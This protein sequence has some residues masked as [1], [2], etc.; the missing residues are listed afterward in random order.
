MTAENK[1]KYLKDVIKSFGSDISEETRKAVI[2]QMIINA[3]T[4]PA[5]RRDGLL[6]D[7]IENFI[8]ELPNDMAHRIVEDMMKSTEKFDPTLKEHMIKNMVS[9]LQVLP[10]EVRE[11]ALDAIIKNLDGLSSESKQTLLNDILLKMDEPGV[12]TDCE[13][14]A[15]R[16]MLKA[17]IF[18]EMI[19]NSKNLNA[20]EQ[21]QIVL[22]ILGKI[23]MPTNSDVSDMVL[24]E[25]VKDIG[26][27]STEIRTR[28]LD[29]IQKSVAK[30]DTA[31]VLI[32][33]CL[34]YADC[35]P[36]DIIESLIKVDDNQDPLVVNEI[37]KNFNKLPDTYKDEYFND[38]VSKMGTFD[39]AVKHSILKSLMTNEN[40][41]LSDDTVREKCIDDLV[42][43]LAVEDIIHEAISMSP[44]EKNKFFQNLLKRSNNMDDR[45]RGMLVDE[46]LKNA[47]DLDADLRE[48][49]LES[50]F[51]NVAND[52]PVEI[53]QKLMNDIVL[54]SSHM[55]LVDSREGKTISTLLLNGID[56]CAPDIKQ[57]ALNAFV[58]NADKLNMD[59]VDKKSFLE[60]IM[61]KLDD[62]PDMVSQ[63]KTINVLI[64]NISSS[65]VGRKSMDKN[66]Q[67][68]NKN[69]FVVDGHINGLSGQL[70]GNIMTSGKCPVEQ[71]L[72]S[73]HRKS[74]G[75]PIGRQTS[76]QNNTTSIDTTSLADL[77]GHSNPLPNQIKKILI[78][79]AN[80]NSEQSKP[81]DP[82][83]HE[84]RNQFAEERLARSARKPSKSTR[85]S[86]DNSDKQTKQKIRSEIVADMIVNLKSVDNS[87]KNKLL[88]EIL[89]KPSLFNN[90]EAKE[91]AIDSMIENISTLPEEF[92]VKMLKNIAKNIGQLSDGF[93]AKV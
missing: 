9:S 11:I 26:Q 56:N 64:R 65:D 35:M 8:N 1:S 48:H 4:L 32:E 43:Q 71:G 79:Q 91:A 44:A 70:N 33:E 78:K 53:V 46:L 45:T 93:K 54:A 30:S 80:Q 29:D 20:H 31:T 25:L 90:T 77:A 34:K 85:K 62:I 18:K 6:Q 55:E 19:K 37:L 49:V 81:D 47:L 23:G 28:V 10:E 66:G 73:S 88:Q 87:V 13:T 39:E 74:T 2:E 61:K 16:R 36:V 51:Q 41:V 38:L 17:D 22:G 59:S 68:V 86:K 75:N 52:L 69:D 15:T 60:N 83:L 50:F 7:L 5:E 58:S 76:I 40:I 84:E 24:S 89:T 14:S 92:Q 82:A 72:V 63:E 57:H 21:Q 12:V 67:G 3:K 27:L 42:E